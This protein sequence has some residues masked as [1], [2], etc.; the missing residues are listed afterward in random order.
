MVTVAHSYHLFPQV[1]GG[2]EQSLAQSRSVDPPQPACAGTHLRNQQISTKT[3]QTQVRAGFQLI[4]NLESKGQDV[5][6]VHAD[7]VPEVW[8]SASKEPQR[9]P[10]DALVRRRLK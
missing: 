4:Q 1:R 7:G 3:Q 10:P 8:H 9:R 2:H 6:E 5:R